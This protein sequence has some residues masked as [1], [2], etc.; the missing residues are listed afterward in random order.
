MSVAEFHNALAAVVLIVAGCSLW[1]L[2][3]L[4]AREHRE[5]IAEWYA[6]GQPVGVMWRPPNVGWMSAER[7]R[8]QLS[9]WRL[10][11][12]WLVATPPWVRGDP[13]TLILFR[14]YRAC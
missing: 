14:V 4:L 6:D 10:T 13:R 5:H 9:A 11:L 2:D 7:R 3:A 8:G 1:V 12:R